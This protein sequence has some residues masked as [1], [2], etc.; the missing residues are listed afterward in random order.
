MST[1]WW[2]EQGAK[3]TTNPND[4]L[5]YLYLPIDGIIDME[6]HPINRYVTSTRSD[7]VLKLICYAGGLTLKS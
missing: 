5:N 3:Q 7:D 2:S 1:K 6:N 4:N